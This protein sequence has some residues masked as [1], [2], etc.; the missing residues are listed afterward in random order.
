LILLYRIATT[1]FLNLADLYTEEEE[2]SFSL[3]DSP[4]PSK[5]HSQY[6]D[7]PPR[8][9]ISPSLMIEMLSGLYYVTYVHTFDLSW[10]ALD[11]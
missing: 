5:R 7:L 11:C 2:A 6:G 3:S 1:G 9:A 8:L 4:P 10:K